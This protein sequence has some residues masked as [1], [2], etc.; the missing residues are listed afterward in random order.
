MK[1]KGS[2]VNTGTQETSC[3]TQTDEMDWEARDQLLKP[4]FPKR[5]RDHSSVSPKGGLP[6]NVVLQDPSWASF[7]SN[8]AEH[9]STFSPARMIQVHVTSQP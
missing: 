9:L 3:L 2:L 5:I 1:G 8:L 6:L 7:L 4:T